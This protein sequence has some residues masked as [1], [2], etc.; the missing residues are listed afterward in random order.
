MEIRP[1]MAIEGRAKRFI[2]VE[3]GKEKLRIDLNKAMTA[4]ELSKIFEEKKRK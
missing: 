4:D 2:L 3:D 1:I